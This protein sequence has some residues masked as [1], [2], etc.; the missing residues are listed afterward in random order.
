MTDPA[1][2]DPPRGK[3]QVFISGHDAVQSHHPVMAMATSGPWIAAIQRMFPQGEYALEWALDLDE[4]MDQLRHSDRALGI[5]EVSFE[6]VVR[7]C[8]RLTHWTT[9]QTGQQTLLGI[10]PCQLDIQ[11][12]RRAAVRHALSQVGFAA[13]VESIA[14]RDQLRSWTDRH[15]DRVRDL[16]P[17]QDSIEQQVMRNLPW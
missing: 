17:R 15:F 1:P 2:I 13:L 4:V 7:T 10:L 9:H 8:Q 5:I 11:S 14:Q 12:S 3:Q 16:P 6:T